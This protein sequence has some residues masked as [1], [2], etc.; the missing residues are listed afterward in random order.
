MN[1]IYQILSW[2]VIGEKI[3]FRGKDFTQNNLII[4]IIIKNID[5]YIVEFFEKGSLPK[6]NTTRHEFNS[7]IRNWHH[8]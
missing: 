5:L 8:S 4:N 1:F 7:H 3:I 6:Y 2:N